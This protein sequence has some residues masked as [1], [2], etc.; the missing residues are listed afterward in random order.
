M[1]GFTHI[2]DNSPPIFSEAGGK[3]YIEKEGQRSTNVINS[4][5]LIKIP[6]VFRI[7]E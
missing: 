6:P 5:F 4:N 1:G 3:I 2:F 7:L